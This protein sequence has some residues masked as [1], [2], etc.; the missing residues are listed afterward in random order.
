M[1]I[2]KAKP[3]I[4]VRAKAVAREGGY[5]AVILGGLGILGGML[6]AV[7]GTTKE[8]QIGQNLYDLSSQLVVESE[9]VKKEL[10]KVLLCTVSP[11]REIGHQLHVDTRQNRVR[12]VF[13]VHGANGEGIVHASGRFVNGREIVDSVAVETKGKVVRVTQTGRFG[14]R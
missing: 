4:A 13:Y 12:I 2:P 10:G 8:H 1:Q 11:Y 9:Q 3:S 5:I 7:Y 14:F 6:W